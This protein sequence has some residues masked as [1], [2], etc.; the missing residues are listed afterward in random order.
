MAEIQHLDQA[1]IKEALIDIRVSS[2]VA[3]SEL[4]KE[5]QNFSD[6]YPTREVIH[7]SKFGWKIAPGNEVSS[8]VDQ[9][10][11]GYKYVST[12]KKYVVQ[13]RTDG[14][15]FSRLDPYENWETMRDTAI[16]FWGIY[17]S[18]AKP[19]AISRIAVRYVN[20]LNIPQGHIELEDYL[21]SPPSVPPGLP[22]GVSNFLSRITI[23]EHESGMSCHITQNLESVGSELVTIVLDIDAFINANYDVESQELW[24]DFE[25]LHDFKNE[26]FFKS[27]TEKTVELFK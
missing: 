20:A 10:L 12:D 2:S 26:A 23:N 25:K 22:Q 1:P 3:A 15:T 5:H 14:F 7:H 8:T 21:V 9:Q 18:I 6:E 4:D 13:F 24:S 17:C 27:I 16:R 19:E 11:I